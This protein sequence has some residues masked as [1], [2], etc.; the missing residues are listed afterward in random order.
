M[1]ADPQALASRPQI[2]GVCFGVPSLSGKVTLGFLRSWTK[3]FSLLQSRG[4]NASTIQVPG[5]PFIAKARNRIVTD[6][7]LEFQG[8]DSLFFI[9][10]DIDWPAEKVIEF[11]ERPEGIVAGVYPQK[12]EGVDFPMALAVDMDK[13]ELIEKDGLFKAIRIPGGF[14]RI[15]RWVLERL[16]EPPTRMFLDT[17]L[18]GGHRQFFGIFE[19]GIGM[20][21]DPNMPPHWWGEDYILSRKCEVLGIDIWIDPFITF[22]HVGGRRWE[23]AVGDHMDHYRNKAR[24]MKDDLNAPPPNAVDIQKQNL[25]RAIEKVMP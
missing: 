6:F 5:D 12:R 16:A 20:Q 15:K 3:T 24:K 19:E 14:V 21:E 1:N 22:G 25:Q 2:G 17:D 18:D 7:L 4:I 10:D 8:F 11:L 13:G 9:D 23:D